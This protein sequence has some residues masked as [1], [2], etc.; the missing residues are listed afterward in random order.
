MY[1]SCC[2]SFPPKLKERD[3]KIRSTKV[4]TGNLKHELLNR[5]WSILAVNVLRSNHNNT[6]GVQCR[7]CKQN[8]PMNCAFN[9]TISKIDIYYFSFV[10]HTEVPVGCK[11]CIYSVYVKHCTD[12][13]S[14][15][16]PAQWWTAVCAMTYTF[17]TAV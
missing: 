7:V 16:H 15:Q 12:S 14:Q 10:L 9:K 17:L 2:T 6:R 4:D 8:T 13:D 5:L 1:W 3:W 11:M